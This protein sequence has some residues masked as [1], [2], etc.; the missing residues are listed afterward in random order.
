MSK[1][2]QVVKKED[3][4]VMESV[5][6]VPAFL[7]KS[8]APRG[9]EH[10]SQ[11]DLVIPRLELVQSLS[12]CRKKTDV[13]YIE[14]AE[15]GMMY[16]SVTR[17]LYGPEV[18]VVPVSFRKEYLLWKDR[19]KGG[20]FRGA[21]PSMEAAAE[22]RAALEDGDGDGVEIT[23]TAQHFCLLQKHDGKMEEIVLSLAK[24]KLK[25]SRKWN[26]IIRIAEVDSF[27]KLYKITGVTLTNAKNQEFYGFDVIQAG[28][29]TEAVYR[30]AE[31]LWSTIEAGGVSVST[32]G[33]TEEGEVSSS[34]STKEF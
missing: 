12:P 27:A 9:A 33:F 21:F 24:S 4:E 22:A 31:K 3:T 34:M 16:N 18:L 17:E 30:R 13:A 11:A 32:E 10:V 26:S 14:G 29:V 28:F 15:E 23:D 19:E 25:M 2:N 1:N 5:N 7:N 20:G 8:V 6:N